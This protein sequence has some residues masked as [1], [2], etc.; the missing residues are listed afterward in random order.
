MAAARVE[1]AIHEQ[2]LSVGS[3]VAEM[4][5]EGNGVYIAERVTVTRVTKAMV[6][7]SSGRRFWRKA[8]LQVGHGSGLKPLGNAPRRQIVPLDNRHAAPL[9]KESR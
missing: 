9:I 2:W 1:L 6:F 7:T 4:V 5:Y 8:R 3:E